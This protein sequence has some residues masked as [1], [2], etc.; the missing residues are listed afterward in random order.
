MN[1]GGKK[2]S[3]MVKSAKKTKKIDSLADKKSIKSI[4]NYF[5]SLDK[6]DKIE[7]KILVEASKSFNVKEDKEVR[8][9]AVTATGSKKE[10]V[11]D[12]V[13]AFE[14]MMLHKG[15]D[16]PRKTPGKVIKRIGK[17]ATRKK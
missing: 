16:A 6:S 14:L 12:R 7:G 2:G 8:I 1:K 9:D 17:V 4:K 5:E 15:G 3:P 11:I 13:N 10:R